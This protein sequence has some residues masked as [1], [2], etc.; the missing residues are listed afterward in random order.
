MW[1]QEPP[2]R[3]VILS[4]AAALA[5]A[6]GLQG[7]QVAFERLPL[8]IL[9]VQPP[10]SRVSGLPGELTV[11]TTSCRT[12]PS[13]EIRQR[14]VSV[15]LQE[16]A[17]FGFTIVAPTEDE[18]DDGGRGAGG[19]R[20]PDGWRRFGRSQ[21]PH[22]ALSVAGYWTATPGGPWILEELNRRA[23][24]ASTGSGRGR[25]GRYP[26][27]AAFIS[28]VMCES[29]L[30]NT[31]FQRAIAHHVYIDQAIRARGATAGRAAYV[32]YDAGEAIIAPGD[33]LCTARR[34][35]Y[36]TLAERRAQMGEGARTHCDVVVK[37][38]E[39]GRRILAVGGNVRG[40]VSLKAMPALQARG[41]LRPATPAES[42]GGR[43]VFAHLKLQVGPA[44]AATAVDAGAMFREYGCSGRATVPAWRTAAALFASSPC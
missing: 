21:P 3:T 26:W 41:L 8:E 11:R 12:F 24:Q 15:A 19:V 4:L 37:I 17:Y 6:A 42:P 27:S 14:V 33:L 35:A 44:A 43:T 30:D 25:G 5:A 34:P 9:D 38:D 2:L 36:A 18:D 39:A 31:Q 13:A 7:R 22:L 40:A 16:W 1:E 32:A 10:S 20:S 29:G 28:W 23:R